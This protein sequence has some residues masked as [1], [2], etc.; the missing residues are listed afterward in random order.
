MSV[1]GLCEICD[2][3]D[4]DHNCDRCGMLVCD[5]HFDDDL[6]VCAECAVQFGQRKRESADTENL[7]DGVDTYEL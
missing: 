1:S 5:R 6:A 3:P 4:V 2:R 7:P